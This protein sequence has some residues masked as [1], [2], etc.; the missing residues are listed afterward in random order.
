MHEGHA[1]FSEPP[2]N[3]TRERRPITVPARAEVPPPVRAPEREPPVEAVRQARVA[4]TPG[5]HRR[6]QRARTPLPWQPAPAAGGM[7]ERAQ[8]TA[9]G[10]VS[11]DRTEAAFPRR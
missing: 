5:R 7:P 6:H 8:S 4:A 3:Q 2:L 10:A 11:S 9:A 1:P